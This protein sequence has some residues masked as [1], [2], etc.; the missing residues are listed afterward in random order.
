MILGILNFSFITKDD[1]ESFHN[2]RKFTEPVVAAL[3]KIRSK[4]RIKRT[5]MIFW[6]KEEKF[7]EMPS[8]QQRAECSVMEHCCL[9][10]KSKM[11]FQL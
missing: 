9:I 8:F 6:L 7:L 2:F 4:C 10:Q 1:G 11:L 5:E 3:E